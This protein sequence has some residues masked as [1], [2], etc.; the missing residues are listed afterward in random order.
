MPQELKKL[1]PEEQHIML[2]VIP[3]ITI[4][5]AGADGK[6]DAKELAHGEKITRIRSYDYHAQLKPYFQKVGENYTQRLQELIEELP[7]N[8]ETRQ[9][10]I[11]NRLSKIN[12]ILPKLD[13]TYAKLFYESLLTFAKHVA[14]SS[15]GVFG[16]MSINAKEHKVIRL[17]MLDPVE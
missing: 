3:L 1:S 7:D 13:H 5:V 4:L 10:E 11:S 15:G 16:I 14:K 17:A 9:E 6:I 2:D 12:S 8:T